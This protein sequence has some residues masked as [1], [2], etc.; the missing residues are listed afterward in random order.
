MNNAGRDAAQ[1][2]LTVDMVDVV[3]RLV[4]LEEFSKDHGSRLKWL[5]GINGAILLAH[6]DMVVTFAKAF[7]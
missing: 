4:R 6:A 2:K 1:A 7:F 3:E 5:L